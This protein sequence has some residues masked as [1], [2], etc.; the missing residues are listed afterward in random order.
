MGRAAE[1]L[2]VGTL[3]VLV[4]STVPVALIVVKAPSE[5]VV[6]DVEASSVV[7]VAAVDEA[8]AADDW[9]ATALERLGRVDVES[10]RTAAENRVRAKADAVVVLELKNRM[11]VLIS[12]L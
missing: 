8:A 7:V 4:V 11:V 3:S 10:A 5:A 1:L 2:I 6:A 12:S 9:L